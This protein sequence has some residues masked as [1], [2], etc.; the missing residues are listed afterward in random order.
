MTSKKFEHALPLPLP[1]S[2]PPFPPHSI[3]LSLSLSLSSLSQ[4][5]GYRR[6]VLLIYSKRS[7][8][9]GS[10]N[11]LLTQRKVLFALS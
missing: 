11:E 6:V 10:S 8:L 1:L 9:L 7:P 4:L 3:S 5:F 2:L